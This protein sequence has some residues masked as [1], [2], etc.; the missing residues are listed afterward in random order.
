M[1]TAQVI[2]SATG[3]NRFYGRNATDR[4]ISV[5]VQENAIDSYFDPTKPGPRCN[6]EEVSPCERPIYQRN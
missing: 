4:E 1:G 3:G 5:D 6:A 2:A